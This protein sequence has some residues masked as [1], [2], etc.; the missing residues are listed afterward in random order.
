[1]AKAK[2]IVAGPPSLKLWRDIRLR[3]SLM[4]VHEFI[5][6]KPERSE[7]RQEVTGRMA[8]GVSAVYLQF[9]AINNDIYISTHVYTPVYEFAWYNNGVICQRH[10]GS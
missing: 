10:L 1:M 7:R 2:C 9:L 3:P 6:P 4:I 8:D 5:P